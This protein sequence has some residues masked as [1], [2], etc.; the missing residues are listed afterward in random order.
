MGAVAADTTAAALDVVA[1]YHRH[2]PTQWPQTGV[3][4]ADTTAAFLDGVAAHS[5]LRSS[6]V[7]YTTADSRLLL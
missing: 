5:G 3:T 4:A 7:L 1:V 2:Q 6:A